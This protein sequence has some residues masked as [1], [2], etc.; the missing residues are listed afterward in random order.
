MSNDR[1]IP[2]ATNLKQTYRQ[3]RSRVDDLLDQLESIESEL[4]HAAQFADEEQCAR[5]SRSIRNLG[6]ELGLKIGV[7]TTA[8]RRGRPRKTN[9]NA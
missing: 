3:L 4:N 7:S 2:N 9:D 8:K 6:S 5:Y 1:T